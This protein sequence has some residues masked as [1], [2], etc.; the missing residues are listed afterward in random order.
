MKLSLNEPE[1]FGDTRPDME[2]LI[3]TVSRTFTTEH[4]DDGQHQDISCRSISALANSDD[5][6]IIKFDAGIRFGLGP[7]LFDDPGTADRHA[8]FSANISANVNDWRPEGFDKCCALE[9]AAIGANRDVTGLYQ[10]AAQKRLLLLV[11]IGS[12]NVV[13]KHASASSA[14]ANRFACPGSA[15]YTLTANRGAVLYY[16]AIQLRWFILG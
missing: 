3:G 11:N 6:N 5:A 7:W 2:S 16:S 4:T 13:L 9:V 14:A 10:G 1:K 8:S 15:D 12:N